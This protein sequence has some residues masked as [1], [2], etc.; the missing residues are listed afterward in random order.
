VG[1][2]GGKGQVSR[3]FDLVR[4]ARTIKPLERIFGQ[5]RNLTFTLKG[6]RSANAALPAERGKEKDRK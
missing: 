6:I 3:N 4:I 1:G 5:G 2:G